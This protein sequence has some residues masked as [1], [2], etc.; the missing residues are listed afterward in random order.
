MLTSSWYD[1]PSQM[2]RD[3]GETEMFCLQIRPSAPGIEEAATRSKPT[4]PTGGCAGR[5]AGGNKGQ[6]LELTDQVLRENTLPSVNPNWRQGER[7]LMGQLRE[8]HGL[9]NILE[10]KKTATSA[11]MV[12]IYS[13]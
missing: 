3:S 1:G 6:P 10:K 13:V 4:G 7:T 5:E 11:A 12:I 9:G 8:K 2:E